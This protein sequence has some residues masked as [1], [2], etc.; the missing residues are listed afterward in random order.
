MSTPRLELD[1]TVIGLRLPVEAMHVLEAQAL[2]EHTPLT[3]L[4][5]RAVMRGLSLPSEDSK[6]STEDSTTGS[7]ARQER[8]ETAPAGARRQRRASSTRRKAVA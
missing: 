4:V 7:R 8:A 6:T 3:I 1:P 2:E 5:R